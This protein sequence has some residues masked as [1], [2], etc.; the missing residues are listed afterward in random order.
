MRR[1]K[2]IGEWVLLVLATVVVLALLFVDVGP[3]LFPYQ[4]LIVRSGSMTPTIPTGSL[5]LYKKTQASQLKVGQIIVFTAPDDPNE[6]IT[7]RIYAIETSSSGRYFV[8]KGDAN[9]VPDD[10][11][12]PAIG[13]GWVEFWHVPDVGYVLADVQSGTARILLIAVPAVAI[14]VLMLL[15]LRRPRRGK[16]AR[17]AGTDAPPPQPPGV[18]DP[19]SERVI[20]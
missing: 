19:P 9:A 16:H 12:V 4:A 1:I 15:D 8:T 18:L 7:H 10:W 5:V 2:A 17:G 13:T 11:R 6:K 3:R 14:G 20:A